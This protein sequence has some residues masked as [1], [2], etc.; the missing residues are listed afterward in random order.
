MDEQGRAELASAEKDKENVE[1]AFDRV[2]E[3]AG[4]DAQEYFR[5]RI[6]GETLENA[7]AHAR[8]G[9]AKLA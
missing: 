4:P 8:E 3:H 1:A 2:L 5:R 9:A 6:Q 7:P